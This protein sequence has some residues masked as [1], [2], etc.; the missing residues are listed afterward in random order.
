V[1]EHGVT[2]PVLRDPGGR[3]AASYRTTGYPETFEIDA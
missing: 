2:F 3:I 1:K